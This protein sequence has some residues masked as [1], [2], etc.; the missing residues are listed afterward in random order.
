MGQGQDGTYGGGGE[1]AKQVSQWGSPRVTTN[2]GSASPQC[3]GKGSR[4]EDQ[5]GKQKQKLNPAWVEQ[6]MGLPV[7]WTAFDCS[8]MESCPHKPKKRGESYCKDSELR[9]VEQVVDGVA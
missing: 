6:L 3:T 7:G 1:F 5:V 2:G 9:Q 4:L 8:A